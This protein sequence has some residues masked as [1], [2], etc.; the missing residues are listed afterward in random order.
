[1]LATPG[2]DVAPTRGV[3]ALRECAE[4][5]LEARCVRPEND[6][7]IGQTGYCANRLDSELIAPPL[8]L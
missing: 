3:G 7:S 8:A 5:A 1:M 4:V 2:G 6:R